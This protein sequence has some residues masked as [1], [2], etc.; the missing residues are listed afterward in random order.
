MERVKT[1]ATHAKLSTLRLGPAWATAEGPGGSLGWGTWGVVM[2]IG[3]ER[4]RGELLGRDS[5]LGV[6]VTGLF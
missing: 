3:Q 6:V 2:G 5:S 1:I 4:G